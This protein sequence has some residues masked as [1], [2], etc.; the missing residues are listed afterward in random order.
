MSAITEE[1]AQVIIRQTFPKGGDLKL[2]VP[3]GW[4]I[5]ELKEEI[6][7]QYP[8]NPNVEQQQLVLKGK[9]MQDE[10]LTM[11]EIL[12]ESP[13]HDNEDARLPVFCLL[14]KRSGLTSSSSSLLS[15]S[16]SPSLL[17]PTISSS[18]SPSSPQS[19]IPAS[20]SS[21]PA[22]PLRPEAL[23]DAPPPHQ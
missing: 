14:L 8:G 21:F 15:S 16:S 19:P 10:Q 22:Q 23:A 7:Q 11:R 1:Q 18:S 2:T 9:L 6:H 13:S 17:S 5:R 12:H 4:T 3:K 20:S